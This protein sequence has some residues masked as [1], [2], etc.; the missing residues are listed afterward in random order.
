VVFREVLGVMY[1][2]L[3]VDFPEVFT[4]NPREVDE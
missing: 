4:R 1:D 3:V 2:M